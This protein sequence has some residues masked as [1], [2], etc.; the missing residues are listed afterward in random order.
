LE[1]EVLG[2]VV[3]LGVEVLGDTVI[4]LP[5]RLLVEALVQKSQ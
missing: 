4:Q 1:V 3:M 5:V 2:Q